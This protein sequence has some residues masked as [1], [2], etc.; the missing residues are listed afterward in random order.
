MLRR[1]ACECMIRS[2]CHKWRYV[3][4]QEGA[5]SQELQ[6]N[7]FY[8]WLQRNHPDTLNFQRA[9]DVPQWVSLW[10]HQEFAEYPRAAQVIAAMSEP[11]GDEAQAVVP[12]RAR[13][14]R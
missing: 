8:F 12:K 9:R 10:F 2:L 5:P 7:E 14:D 6:V 1:S 11:F 4:G 13:G 3:T